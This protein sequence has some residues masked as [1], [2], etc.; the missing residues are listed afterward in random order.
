MHFPF[1]TAVNRGVVLCVS[2]H[3]GNYWPRRAQ[4]PTYK[5]LAKQVSRLGALYFTLQEHLAAH[6]TLFIT[7]HSMIAEI[8][9][10]NAQSNQERSD[11]SNQ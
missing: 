4:S 10:S 8:C 1:G 2:G 7:H 11:N 6:P 3:G 5:N 9:C